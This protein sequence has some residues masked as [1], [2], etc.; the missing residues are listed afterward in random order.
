[1]CIYI[2]TSYIILCDML[3]LSRRTDQELANI[4]NYMTNDHYYYYH[5]YYYYYYYY[6]YHYSYC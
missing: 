3:A 5:H 2:Y 1:M 6:Y 4:H